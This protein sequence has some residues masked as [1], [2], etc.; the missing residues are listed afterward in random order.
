MFLSCQKDLDLLDRPRRCK[1]A[2]KRIDILYVTSEDSSRSECTLCFGISN[3]NQEKALVAWHNSL[4]RKYRRSELCVALRSF[5]GLEFNLL[6]CLVETPRHAQETVI[7]L[8]DQVVKDLVDP[9]RLA[10][11][12]IV[13]N[14]FL[15]IFG[16]GELIES[17]NFLK[18]V[19]LES[20]RTDVSCRVEELILLESDESNETWVWQVEAKKEVL[21]DDS[22]DLKR[23]N[24]PE[25]I[26]S[27][28][29]IFELEDAE[30]R[31]KKRTLSIRTS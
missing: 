2:I 29:G 5:E 9:S 24:F 17:P 10:T 28:E 13:R 22:Q 26:L 4:D 27:Q 6:A 21:C 30:M 7:Y 3:Q 11:R 14:A 1:C 12:N 15:E 16:F 31:S 19:R 20:K 25:T 18:N 8:I 23:W